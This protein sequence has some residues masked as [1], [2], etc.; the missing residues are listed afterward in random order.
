MSSLIL[1]RSLLCWKTCLPSGNQPAILW[2]KDVSHGL[3]PWTT[4]QHRIVSWD[5][6]R[7]NVRPFLLDRTPEFTSWMCPKLDISYFLHLWLWTVTDTQVYFC[8]GLWER[9]HREGSHLGLWWDTVGS[10]ICNP[11]ASCWTLRSHTED[12]T[13][14]VCSVP[15]SP[16]NWES[17]GLWTASPGSGSVGYS[18]ELQER[19]GDK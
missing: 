18:L 6:D 13:L 17:P 4:R 19:E 12:R 2:P 9:N 11:A 3:G 7:E 8:H 16:A 1:S 10:L 15:A 5:V 14:T